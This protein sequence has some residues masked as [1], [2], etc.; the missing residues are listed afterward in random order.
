MSP[1][2]E[3]LL[4]W[5][6]PHTAAQCLL[7]N[8]PDS[9]VAEACMQRHHKVQHAHFARA[10]HLAHAALNLPELMFPQT[11]SALTDVYWVW[12]KAKDEALMLLAWLAPQLADDGQLWIVGHNKGGIKSAPKLLTEQGWQVQKVGS[13]KHCA[14]LRVRKAT[15]TA[16]EDFDVSRFWKTT[17]IPDTALSL[18]TLPGVFCHGKIDQGSRIFLPHLAD[19]SGPVLDFG[20]GG[21]LL[22]AVAQTHKPAL[23]VVA[24]DHHWLAVLSAQRTASENG[25]I[26]K[27]VWSDVLDEVEG[28][29]RTLITNP[30]FHTG[31]AT[32][33]DITHQLIAGSKDVLLPRARWLAVVNAHLPYEPWLKQHLNN[34]KRIEHKNGFDVWEAQR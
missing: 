6:Q 22:A 24:T 17:S 26:Y 20:C 28:R 2:S 7:L 15:T 21:G 33:Y 25:L 8:L 27:V 16:V 32:D 4:R 30:P 14:L 23:E 12:P 10:Q 29:F 13:A 9:A 5:F 34:P 19:L 1:Y 11:T 18:W 31:I 3:V